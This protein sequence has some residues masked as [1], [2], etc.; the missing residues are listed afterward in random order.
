MLTYSLIWMNRKVMPSISVVKM[1]ACNP[2]RFSALI[3]TSA[4][5][6]V[7]DDITRIAVLMPAISLGS[8]SPWAG[9]SCPCTTRMKK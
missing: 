2:R 6:S 1:P 4:Q 5:C 7:K 9:H 8:S 3:E